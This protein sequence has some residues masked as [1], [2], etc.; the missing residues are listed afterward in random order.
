[1]YQEVHYRNI[2]ARAQAPE[3]AV[4]LH[5]FEV[6]AEGAAGAPHEALRSLAMPEL[7]DSLMIIAP[8]PGGDYTYLHYGAAL[9]R[10]TGADRT[11]GLL[12]DIPPDAAKFVSQCYDRALADGRP[13]YT[14][15]RTVRTARVGIWERLVL[16]TTA[17]DGQRYIIVFCRPMNFREE[18][19]T[20]LMETSPA[21]IVAVEAKRDDEGALVGMTI[22][23]ANARTAA[24]CGLDQAELVE[25]GVRDV[26][27]FLADPDVWNRCCRAVELRRADQF[28]VEFQLGGR[29]VW[30]QVALALLGDGLVIT[31]TDISA[32]MAK[33]LSLQDRAA[34]LALEVG[35]ERA[36][37]RALSVEIGQ[38]EERERELRRLAE[39]D[40]L[41]ALLN[42][43]SF[44]EH[45]QQAI[46]AAEA[47][48][49][50]IAL[51]IVDL[52]HFK[53]V[54]DTHGH[55]AGDA[56]IRAVADLLLGA[57][58]P[59]KDLVGRFGGEEF[60]LLLGGA[61]AAPPEIRARNG[62][63]RDRWGASGVVADVDLQGRCVNVQAWLLVRG[64][65]RLRPE[66]ANEPAPAELQ[67]WREAE[68]AAETAKLAL[69]GE[70]AYAPLPAAQPG[71][72][73]RQ[74]GRFVI[75]E[76][77]VASVNEQTGQTWLNFGSQWSE[78]MTVSA[79]ARI[80]RMVKRSGLTVARL[81][82]GLVRVR[83]IVESRGGPLIEL[84]SPAELEVAET[85]S[86]P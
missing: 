82:G 36:T 20:T 49:S 77:Q 46:A 79:P 35:I 63:A 39:T 81:Q 71:A 40:P 41:T 83:G 54:N 86:R 50:E 65:A 52:D 30:L 64:L 18:L 85:G 73:L 34:E 12:S 8:A 55:A 31:L 22:L 53:L 32:L 6:L 80:W 70:P 45:A 44:V 74:E 47:D 51:I 33:N 28:D 78:D 76:G 68:R 14:I 56:V 27:P 38:R 66:A 37:R 7:A 9:A 5:Q 2:L 19:L 1:M 57:V 69:W 4:L 72:I 59:E 43:R 25:Q 17:A 60:V 84:A 15:H 11:G 61:S 10:L 3:M 48:G 29:Q 67:A 75:V 24:L 23:A 21:G 26:L 58:D 13:A 16:P 62:G 42:R